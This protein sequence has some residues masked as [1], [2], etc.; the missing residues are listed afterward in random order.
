MCAVKYDVVRRLDIPIQKHRL[1]IKGIGGQLETLGFVSLNLTVNGNE[2]N[3]EFYVLDNLSCSSDGI[4]GQDFLQKYNSLLDFE[5]STITFSNQNLNVTIPLH[6]GKYSKINNH[7]TIPGRCEKI[8]Y[9]QT[10]AKEDCMIVP[11]ELCKGVFLAGCITKPTNGK[12]PVQI[13]NTRES[14]VRL[15]YFRPEI[16]YLKDYNICAFDRNDNSSKRVRDLFSILNLKHLNKEERESIQNICAKYND[17]FYLPDDTL[18]VSNISETEIKLKTDATP[19]YIKPYRMPHSLKN[20][21]ESQLQKLLND[22]IIE[23][24]CSDWSSPIL[25]VPK[26]GDGKTKKWRLVIDFRKLNEKILDDKF[27]LPNITEI[28]DSLSGAVYFSHLDLNSG[29]YQLNLKEECRKYT[30]FTAPSGQYQMTRLPMG[31]KTAPSSFS[32]A[33]TLAMAGLNYEKCFVYLDDLICFGRN[34]E[35]HNK[36]LMVVLERLRKVNLKLNPQKCQFLK[37]EILYLGHVVSEKGIS[38]D[39]E[40]I[41][42]LKNYPTPTTSE[43]VKRFVAFS[44][45]YRKFI[46]NF[47]TI[48]IPLNRLSRKNQPFEWTTECEKSFQDLKNSLITPPILEYPD[49][50]ETNQF[51]LQTDA[52]GIA[53]GA[54]LC[55]SNMKPIAYASR[56]LNK[57]ERNYPTIQKE[58]VAI[59]WAIKYFR[60]YLYGKHFTILTDHKPLIYLFGMRDPSSRLVKFRLILEE[61]SFDIKYIKG[62]ENVI[63]DALSRIVITSDELKSMNEQIACVMTRAQRQRMEEM[64]RTGCKKDA[65]NTLIPSNTTNDGS[66]QPRVVELLRKPCDSVEMIWEKAKKIEKLKREGRI[67]DETEC[68]SYNDKENIIYINLNY[69][70]QLSRVEFVTKLSK[71]CN[72][73]NIKRV[74]ILINEENKITIKEVCDEVKGRQQWTGPRICI[75]RGKKRIEDENE[76]TIIL[77]DFHLLPTSGHAGVRRMLNNIKRK[78]YWP[79]MEYD[80]ARYV[81]KCTKCQRMKHSKHVREPMTI[82]TTASYAFDKIYIDLVGPLPKDYD[83]NCYVLTLQCELSKYIEAYPLPNKE[84]ITVAKALVN[85]FILRFG[86]PKVLASDRGTEFISA[87]MEQVCKLLNIEKI[88]S[89]PYHHQSIGSL[90]NM[91]KHM[92]AFLRIHCENKPDSW[93]HWLPFWTFSFNNTVHTSTKYTPYE[94]VFGRSCNIPSRVK[95]DV[96]PLYNSDNYALE[97]KYRLQNAFQ[98]AQNNL[99]SSKEKRK[100]QYDRYTNPVTYKENDCIL[101]KTE[102]VSKLQPLYEGPFVVIEDMGPNVKIIRNNKITIVHKNNTKPYIE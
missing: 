36:N 1:V 60:P 87:T 97:L 61:Y 84:T 26:K 75:L 92:G 86:I 50:S 100:V 52:S 91:H 78:Y 88:S 54:V 66:D 68:F 57:A 99:M 7:L 31:L 95:Q 102:N 93:S 71:F 44:N 90:E 34:L 80:V 38:P 23:P 16:E 67:V 32:R 28:L 51:V 81:Q 13:L 22:K 20:E 98:D 77:N 25:L 4:I 89:T 14:E 70:A 17:V 37:K 30:A 19:V 18:S 83:G 49:F 40:K 73:I 96:E 76:R 69:R 53:I 21:M 41:S 5:L 55:N 74:C 43:E 12:I 15:V 24:A 85:N 46:P 35:I 58:L 10:D 27:P 101:L 94:L 29:Y 64:E 6:L 45:Y 56:P 82:T 2:L 48:S 33:M 9:L 39:P 11:K 62:Q 79:G 59:V 63:A 3:H 47:A 8:F 42:V 65:E 72:K